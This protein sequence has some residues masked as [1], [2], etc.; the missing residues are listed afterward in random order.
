MTLLAVAWSVNVA[1]GF[2]NAAMSAT[3]YFLKKKDGDPCRWPQ[4]VGF[5]MGVSLMALSAYMA[6]EELSRARSD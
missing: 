4:V 3:I 2:G 1:L 6:A 5:A